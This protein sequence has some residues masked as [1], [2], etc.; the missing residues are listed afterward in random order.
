ML[1]MKNVKSTISFLLISLAFLSTTGCAGDRETEANKKIIED[2][3]HMITVERNIRGAFEKYVAD[4]YIEHNPLEKNDR[5]VLINNFESFFK[6]FPDAKVRIVRMFGEKDLV[7]IHSHWQL[8]GSKGEAVMDIYR[9]ENG[10]IVEHWDVIQE[11]PE[12]PAN[13]NTMF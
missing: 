9:L 11:V 7:L 10:K 8:P 5:E 3:A 2:W 12:N 6:E 4:S 13:D 1:T